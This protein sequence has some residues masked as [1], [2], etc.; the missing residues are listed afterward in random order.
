M[1]FYEIVVGPLGDAGGKLLMVV[2][3]SLWAGIATIL[4]AAVPSRFLGGAAAAALIP[5]AIAWIDAV[6]P[7]AN[8]RCWRPA[9]WHR[10]WSGGRGLFGELIGRRATLLLPGV[11]HLCAGPAL[12]EAAAAAGCRHHAFG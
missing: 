10:L 12:A 7:C 2:P 9:A 5:L 4:R 3:G 1:G 11:L 6:V 8:K